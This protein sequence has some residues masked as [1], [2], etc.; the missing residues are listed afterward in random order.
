[1]ILRVF[2]KKTRVFFERALDIS[3]RRFDISFCA[4]S[5][6]RCA[7]SIYRNIDISKFRQAVAAPKE[8]APQ[9]YFSVLMQ[10][11]LSCFSVTGAGACV[12]RQVALVVFGVD[13]DRVFA[14]GQEGR[15]VEG[16]GNVAAAMAADLRLVHNHA[17][18]IRFVCRHY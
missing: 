8:I 7:A 4:P 2:R 12:M 9:R 14:R 10:S 3:L 18:D 5:I 17:P 1:M 11:S 15:D 6:F 16:E 13:H